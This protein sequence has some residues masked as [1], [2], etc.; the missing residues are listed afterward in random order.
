MKDVLYI[1]RYDWGYHW[2]NPHDQDFEVKFHDWAEEALNPNVGKTGT[3]AE[4]AEMQAH[5]QQVRQN[6]RISTLTPES[7]VDASTNNSL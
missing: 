7:R 1:G 6:E 2:K 5:K 3:A 4:I